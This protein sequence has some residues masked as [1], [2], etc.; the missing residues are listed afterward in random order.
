MKKLFYLFVLMLA[1]CCAWAMAGGSGETTTP[2]GYKVSGTITC[3]D[4]TKTDGSTIATPNVTGTIYLIK[5]GTEVTHQEFTKDAL[6]YAFENVSPGT[7]SIKVDAKFDGDKYDQGETVY[8]YMGYAQ[9]VT[10]SEADITEN[11]A[12][13]HDKTKAWMTILVLEDTDTEDPIADAAVKVTGNNQDL[14]ANTDADGYVTFLCPVGSYTV[15]CSKTGFTTATEP[16]LS[17]NMAEDAGW[18]YGKANVVY[19]TA[20]AP[21]NTITLTGTVTPAPK[22]LTVAI[23]HND[24]EIG[25]SPISDNGTYTIEDVPNQGEIG[26]VVSEKAYSYTDYPSENWGI[27]GAETDPD[28]ILFFTLDGTT[29]AGGSFTKNLTLTR[30]GVKIKCEAKDKVTKETLYTYGSTIKIGTKTPDYSGMVNGMPAGTHNISLKN[31]AGYEDNEGTLTIAALNTLGVDTVINCLFE[32]TPRLMENHKFYGNVQLNP[33][34]QAP[35]SKEPIEGAKVVM[36]KNGDSVD[37]KSTNAEGYFEFLVSG[38]VSDKY[39]F[40]IFHESIDDVKIERQIQPSSTTG[41]EVTSNATF[42]LRVPGMENIKAEPVTVKNKRGVKL[43][44]TWPSELTQNY[45]EDKKYEI[46][47][48]NIARRISGDVYGTSYTSFQHFPGDDGALPT[49]EYIDTTT[50]LQIGKAYVYSFNIVYTK[51]KTAG[52]NT[53]KGINDPEKLTVTLTSSDVVTLKGN[54]SI[55][56]QTNAVMNGGL[57]IAIKNG[58]ELALAEI[59]EGKYEFKDVKLNGLLHYNLVSKAEADA[60]ALNRN[61]S[62]NFKFEDGQITLDYTLRDGDENSVFTNDI[63]IKR[64]GVAVRGIIK[65]SVSN[66]VMEAYACIGTDTVRTDGMG[67]FAFDGMPEGEINVKFWAKGYEGPVIKT[68]TVADLTTLATDYKVM[69][70]E[71]KLMPKNEARVFFGEL[72]YMNSANEA[73]KIAGAKVEM[74]EVG[75]DNAE[76]KLAET[77]TGADGKFE[78]SKTCRTNTTY[79]FKASHE[80]MENAVSNLVYANDT[81]VE[82]RIHCTMK[83][84]ELLGME[85]PKAAQKENELSVKL[86]WT[87]PAAL[88]SNYKKIYQL[89]NVVVKRIC[90]TDTT[91]V[92]SVTPDSTELPATKFVDSNGLK[93]D[94]TYTYFFVMNYVKPVDSALVVANPAALTVKMEVKEEANEEFELSAWKAYA[95]NG[96]LTLVSSTPCQYGVYTSMGALVE[97]GRMSEGEHRVSVKQTG[98]YV[99]RRISQTGISVRK[100]FVK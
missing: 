11:I 23:L 17:S 65:D 22:G 12:L 86:S 97:Q 63:S 51:P 39:L 57:W 15:E 37:M 52:S 62:K 87:W 80:R 24:K 73:V 20:E 56:G 29:A 10:I 85:N 66:K 31:L 88:V 69:M 71:V 2:T 90:G 93:K 9:S 4:P 50:S 55:S 41:T 44:W 89:R 43:S 84:V 28:G 7:Y 75:A 58:N 77:T 19:L 98:V 5:D 54:V 46:S 83:K 82:V 30:K 53:N 45:G 67:E 25:D 92:G 74:Y 91:A 76:T 42:S 59:K 81:R 3:V 61:R 96:T 38:Y 1:G 13:T 26:I 34:A 72:S 60:E 94:E 35:A 36:Y 68:I 8:A 14:T 99:V 78:F 27:V 49:P 32:M 70:G 21:A 6:T 64:V 95:N 40:K 33:S 47:M 16:N 18:V 100:V 48:V 79:K